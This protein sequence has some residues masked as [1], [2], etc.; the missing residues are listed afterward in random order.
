MDFSGHIV[1]LSKA[2]DEQYNYKHIEAAYT[3]DVYDI[4]DFS[5]L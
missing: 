2:V 4:V 5:G 1:V 3:K